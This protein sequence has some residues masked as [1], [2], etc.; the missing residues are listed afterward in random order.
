V[1]LTTYLKLPPR[2]RRVELHFYSLCT[3]IMVCYVVIFAFTYEQWCEMKNNEPVGTET[4]IFPLLVRF[5][6]PCKLHFRFC[7][8]FVCLPDKK[9][10]L[11]PNTALLE[12][13]HLI[14]LVTFPW[15]DRQI[16]RHLACTINKP[17]YFL[18]KTLIPKNGYIYRV[19]EI[20]NW[21]HLLCVLWYPRSF[22]YVI[23]DFDL[24]GSLLFL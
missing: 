4:H 14:G 6:S 15:L 21:K 12:T 20:H 8:P 16:W 2:L 1:A 5:T 13:R 10:E 11:P 18:L 3:P 19:L 17:H 9:K 22:Y 23:F 24:E 7:P